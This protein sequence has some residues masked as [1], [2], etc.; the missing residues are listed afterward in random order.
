MLHS[1]Q[2]RKRHGCAEAEAHHNHGS[3]VFV[4]KPVERGQNIL[5]LARAIML[6]F[7]Q[8]R[9]AKVE[10]QHR[11]AQ[12][13]LRRVEHLHGV[14]H[15]LV[16]HGAAALGM[17]MAD[18]RGERRS[19]QSLVQN[20]LE[21]P[22]RTGKSRLR[23]AGFRFLSRANERGCGDHST[24]H[25]TRR[26]RLSS[27]LVFIRRVNRSSVP[28]T[29]TLNRVAQQYPARRTAVRP[30]RYSGSMHVRRSSQLDPI[31]L[32]RH[33]V[34]IESTT[35]H[36]GAVGDFL[37]GFPRRIVAGLWKRRRFRSRLRAPCPAP[38]WNVY[39]GPAGQ[40]PDLVFST[41]LD[42]VPPYIS[43]H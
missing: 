14:V 31:R 27:I 9:A 41:H 35:Y 11:P 13:E 33:L 28:R 3:I 15:D 34:E 40:T 24:L 23:S 25:S 20:R 7:A 5:G 6:A 26:F 22:G 19:G 1:Q 43:V 21:P 16:V 8:S 36:E 32:T 37:A 42:T 39:A 2:A 38:R 18:Q 12:S 4:F 29:L 30:V 17:G 10:A